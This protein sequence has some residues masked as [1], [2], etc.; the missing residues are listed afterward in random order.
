MKKIIQKILSIFNYKIVPL[1]LPVDFE[2]EFKRIHKLCRPYTMTSNEN[3]YALYMAIKYIADNNIPG[4]LIECGVW[5][6]GSAMLMAYTLLENENKTKNIYL[7]DTFAGMAEPS[8]IDISR[9]NSS[10]A[11]KI[12]KKR[13]KKN[14]NAWCY[15]SF[16]EVS[17]NMLKT[18]YPRKK[19]FLVEGKV[20]NTIP[21]IAPEKISL[22]RLDTDWYKS[23][24]HEL[25]HL[26]PRLSKGGVLIIDD[27]GSW[28]GARKA[29]DGYIQKNNIKILLNRI[30]G[31][32]R[33]GIKL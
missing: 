13:K 25:I 5:K 18:K 26:F 7:Y 31:T 16:N 20:E 9:V 29:T 28:E 14:Y 22:L 30:D 12:W 19:I 15:S 23:T 2:N 33:M 4:D 3:M 21:K 17:A 27:Y 11:Y 1:K 10:S 6:G 8:E 24:K 32:A